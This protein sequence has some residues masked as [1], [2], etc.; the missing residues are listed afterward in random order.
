M[1]ATATLLTRTSGKGI[2]IGVLRASSVDHCEVIF[3]QSLEPSSQLSFRLFK[4][5]Y[6]NER[7]MVCSQRKLSAQKQA[8]VVRDRSIIFTFTGTTTCPPKWAVEYVGLLAA[9]PENP[10]ENIC[11]DTATSKGLLTYP[12]KDLTV[13]ATGSYS[14]YDAYKQQDAVSCVVCSI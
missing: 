2:C 3:L 14:A 5:S 8:C 10:G 4:I 12:S 13:I 6:P 7:S 1:A 9:N 11:V